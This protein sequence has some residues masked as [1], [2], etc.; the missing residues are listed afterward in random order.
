MSETS[1]ILIGSKVTDEDVLRVSVEPPESPGEKIVIT[2]NWCDKTTWYQTATRVVDEVATC[3]DPGTYTEYSVANT[4]VIDTYHGKI[5]GEDDLEDAGSNSYRVTVKVNDVTKTEQNPHLGSGGDYT[6]NY[7]TGVVT[8]LVA[9]TAPDVV[10]VTYHYA[11]DSR[12]KFGPGTGKVLKLVKAEVQYSGDF[13]LGD[14]VMFDVMWN[15]TVVVRTT[16]Y[17]TKRDLFNEAQGVYPSMPAG[18]TGWR[19][20]DQAVYTLPFV[21]M[22]VSKM[23]SSEQISLHLRLEHDTECVGTYATATF[24]CLEEDEDS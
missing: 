17:K 22:A 19:E 18:G 7:A 5:S 3:D 1:G 15:D 10:K 11:V 24:Y 8:F 4:Y 20:L 13:R 23:K 9:L 6:I 14:T 12:F 21:Y 2:P 16:K